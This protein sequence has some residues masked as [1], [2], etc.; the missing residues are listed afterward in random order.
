MGDKIISKN[1][2]IYNDKGLL[3]KDLLYSIDNKVASESEYKY[4]ENGNKIEWIYRDYVEDFEYLYKYEY[5][6]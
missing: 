3:V 6:D 2:Y 5:S 1:E 4:D